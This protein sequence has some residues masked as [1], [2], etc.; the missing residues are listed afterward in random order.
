MQASSNVM[1]Q[2]TGGGMPW[3]GKAV[4]E[5]VAVEGA[6]ASALPG[7]VAGRLCTLVGDVPVPVPKTTPLPVEPNVDGDVPSVGPKVD[8]VGGRGAIAEASPDASALDCAKPKVM[9]VVAV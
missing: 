7:P 6:P 5:E 8:G 1:V 3:I 2:P 9:E 4:P